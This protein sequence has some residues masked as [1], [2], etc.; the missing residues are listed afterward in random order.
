MFPNTKALRANSP[1]RKA[2]EDASSDWQLTNAGR[3]YYLNYANDG[4]FEHKY[5][6]PLPARTSASL[7]PKTAGAKPSKDIL[8]IPV[9]N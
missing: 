9:F 1:A 2:A 5:T 3:P 6:A 8:K 4:N 7:R